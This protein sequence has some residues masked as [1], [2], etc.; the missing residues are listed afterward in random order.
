MS[1]LS[2][3]CLAIFRMSLSEILLLC[4]RR[5]S[6]PRESGERHFSLLTVSPNGVEQQRRHTLHI[7]VIEEQGKRP[8][9]CRLQTAKLRHVSRI[10]FMAGTH[11]WQGCSLRLEAKAVYVY[12]QSWLARYYN[13]GFS[14]PLRYLRQL[15]R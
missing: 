15:G 11:Q 2:S 4:R 8:A 5:V 1:T 13:G 7:P 14:R 3:I 9:S 10:A 6:F 12:H